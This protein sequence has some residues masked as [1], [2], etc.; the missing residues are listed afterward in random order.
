MAL[1]GTVVLAISAPFF[2]PY[3]FDFPSGHPGSP[4]SLSPPT[5]ELRLTS[6]FH[7]CMLSARLS[8]YMH[9][10]YIAFQIS[11][12]G[13]TMH[14]QRLSITIESPSA[15]LLDSSRGLVLLSGVLTVLYT[16]VHLPVRPCPFSLFPQSST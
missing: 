16:F 5:F 13:E 6:V 10:V 1:P 15:S 3:G 8:I 12:E 9:I 7:F 2:C 14:S 4:M 11:Y